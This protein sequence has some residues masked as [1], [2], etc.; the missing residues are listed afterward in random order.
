LTRKTKAKLQ[1]FIRESQMGRVEVVC[2]E[3]INN[4]FPRHS[5]HSYCLGLVEQGCRVVLHKGT[6]THIPK[7][8]LFVLQPKQSH[9]CRSPQA[10]MHSYSV[11]C[12]PINYMAE[13]VI[14]G[15][16]IARAGT[17]FLIYSDRRQ[18][19]GQRFPPLNR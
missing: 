2:A 4:N 10:E 5:H 7:S 16:A 18:K 15:R 8:G 9:A 3:G 13:L 14:P 17:V 1:S 6:A 12:L 11:L 19:L